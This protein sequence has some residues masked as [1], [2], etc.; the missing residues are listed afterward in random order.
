MNGI[1]KVSNLGFLL[2]VLCKK[3]ETNC[4]KSICSLKYKVW[5]S[6]V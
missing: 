1:Q 5:A 4:R 6:T 3:E 2:V